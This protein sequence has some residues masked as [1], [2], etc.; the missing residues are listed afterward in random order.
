LRSTKDNFVKPYTYAS[1][2][3][4]VLR[5]TFVIYAPWSRSQFK[6]KGQTIACPGRNLRST[7]DNFVKPYT[8]MHHH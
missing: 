2:L 5:T 6:V 3:D 8:H 1:S 4:G 7:K